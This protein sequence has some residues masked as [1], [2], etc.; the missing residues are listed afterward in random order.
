MY[1]YTS[2]LFNYDVEIR[3]NKENARAAIYSR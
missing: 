2:S 1:L 3:V